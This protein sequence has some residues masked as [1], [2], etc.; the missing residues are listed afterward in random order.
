MPPPAMAATV[1]PGSPPH[2]P[3]C[4]AATAS[5]ST[6]SRSSDFDAFR[7][8]GAGRGG[9]IAQ[10]GVV[11][12]RAGQTDDPEHRRQMGITA[13]PATQMGDRHGRRRRPNKV[14]VRYG[15]IKALGASL[16]ATWHNAAQTFSMI[17]KML[18]GQA[19]TRICP[20]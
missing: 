18:S 9:Q 12:E 16:Q 6:A 15:P 10:A 3:A 1:V 5:A 11:V 19:S 17:G 14:T 13:R 7:Q 2:W 4:R 20:A 8:T